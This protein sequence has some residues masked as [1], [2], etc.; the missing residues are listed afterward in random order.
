MR[1]VTSIVSRN[2]TNK[3]YILHSP[4]LRKKKAERPI[5]TISSTIVIPFLLARLSRNFRV[6]GG[7]AQY[8]S[9]RRNIVTR[10]AAD[11]VS[12]LTAT[13]DAAPP[14]MAI[15]LIFSA[16]LDVAVAA[17]F[18][19]SLAAKFATGRGPRTLFRSWRERWLVTAPVKAATG[20]WLPKRR[21]MASCNIQIAFLYPTASAC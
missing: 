18:V 19:A 5:F 10:A 8:C 2:I 17:C 11:R 1:E 15:G 4:Q 6:R 9:A 12:V 16:V 3:R 7:C 13:V 21:V 14:M 20:E